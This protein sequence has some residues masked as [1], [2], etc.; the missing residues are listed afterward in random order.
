MPANI[1]LGGRVS[2]CEFGVVASLVAQ[3][4]KNLPA[5]WET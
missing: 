4:V 5:M 3:P 1:T 2:T